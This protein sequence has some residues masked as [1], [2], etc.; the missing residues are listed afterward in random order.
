M[1]TYLGHSE[2]PTQSAM[3]N[4]VCFDDD[5]ALPFREFEPLEVLEPKE[6]IVPLEII[7]A[8]E[9]GKLGN[10]LLSPDSSPN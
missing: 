6:E 5:Y 10:H 7:S 9:F 2:K 4:M 1:K 8:R 3:N